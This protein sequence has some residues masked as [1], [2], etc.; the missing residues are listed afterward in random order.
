MPYLTS[1]SISSFLPVCLCDEA[2]TATLFPAVPSGSSDTSSAVVSLTPDS[3]VSMGG[4]PQVPV[5]EVNVGL[6]NLCALTLPR[7]YTTSTMIQSLS[8][9]PNLRTLEFQYDERY[10]IH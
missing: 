10:A 9:L 8:M 7:F 4:I 5:A 2:L 6:Q 3:S 1:L